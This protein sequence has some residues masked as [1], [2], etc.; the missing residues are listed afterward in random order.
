M[1]CSHALGVFHHFGEVHLHESDGV[2]LD[3]GGIGLGDAGLDDEF[4]GHF[5]ALEHLHHHG[6]LRVIG[7]VFQIDGLDVFAGFWGFWFF[8]LGEGEGE[9]VVFIFHFDLRVFHRFLGLRAA[10]ANLGNFCSGTEAEFVRIG[11]FVGD[12]D[13][14]GALLFQ[15]S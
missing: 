6:G 2:V 9:E 8:D 11:K 3:V 14:P 7:Q 13:A 1:E 5:H 15:P 12:G 10:G 4:L